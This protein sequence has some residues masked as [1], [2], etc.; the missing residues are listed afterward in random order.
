MIIRDISKKTYFYISLFLFLVL[1][2]A[3]NID[4]SG[5][6]TFS[7]SMGL[8]V[9]RGL[10][11]PDWNFMYDGS[12][13][14]LVNLL[15]LTIGIAFLGSFL[16]TFFAIPLALVSAVNLFPNHSYITKIG[17]LVCNILRSF[18][19]LVLAIIFVK[20]VGPGPFAG[21]LAIGAH[22][23]GMLGKL[24]T[25][26]MENMDENI[27]QEMHAIGANFW[28]VLFFVRFSSLAP[29]WSSL[30][31]NHFEIAVRSA[32]TLGLVGAGGIGAPLIFAI[33]TRNWSKVSIILIGVV[34][35]VFIL[36]LIT[37][38]IRKRLK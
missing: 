14:D 25:E 28:Q 15:V 11:H 34:I 19:E 16:A 5:L 29:I 2:S 3:V 8:E 21:V 6:S 7:L 24:F 38:I 35:T 33:Q 31:L 4:Y 30:A 27:V 10:S 20:V 32:A 1:I 9:I 18:P 13:E 12:G 22:Q 37:G 23:I 36:D 26:E 17:K